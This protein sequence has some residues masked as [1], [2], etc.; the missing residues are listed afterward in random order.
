[1]GMAVV[2]AEEVEEGV[3]ATEMEAKRDGIKVEVR[4]DIILTLTKTQVDNGTV[5]LPTWRVVRLDCGT[6]DT[7]QLGGNKLIEDR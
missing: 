4:G 5:I 1:M 3:E 2:A 7:E 6:Q